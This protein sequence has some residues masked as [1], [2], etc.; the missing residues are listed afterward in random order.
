MDGTTRMVDFG[1][2]L[3]TASPRVR[4]VMREVG[5]AIVVA[6]HALC[7]RDHTRGG[8]WRRHG[9]DVATAEAHLLNVQ[10]VAVRF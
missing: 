6:R 8:L 4:L 2:Q 3:G 9:C 5:G 10:L 7:Q 1:P